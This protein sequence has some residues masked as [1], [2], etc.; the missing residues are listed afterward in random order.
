VSKTRAVAVRGEQG[1]LKPNELDDP[2]KRSAGALSQALDAWDAIH[3]LVTEFLTAVGVEVR[4]GLAGE[5]D[6]AHRHDPKSGAVYEVQ[7]MDREG[8][9]VTKDVWMRDVA[10]DLVVWVEKLSR[11]FA[12]LTKTVDEAARLQEFLSGGPDSRP[13]LSN[14]SDGELIETLIEVVI[15]R[16]LMRHIVKRA[17]DRGIE[18]DLG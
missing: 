11:A 2:I 4:K 15:A 17:R 13:D 8:E 18:V 7:Y 1:L 6:R 12:A 5:A 10:R 14:A 3:P 16:G 9:E